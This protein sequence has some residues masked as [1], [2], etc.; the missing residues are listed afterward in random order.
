MTILKLIK[1][2]RKD[3]G[4]LFVGALAVI[5]VIDFWLIDLP[6]IFKGGFKL[7]QIVY[8]L[9]MSYIS[10]FI[11]YFLVVHIK[12]QKDKQNL[13]TYI[14]KKVAVI[15]SDAKSLIDEM[16]KKSGLPFSN[17]YPSSDELQRISNLIDPHSEAPLF[18]GYNTNRYANWIQY[19]ANSSIRSKEAIQKIFQKM[20]FLETELINI[21][22]N[23]EDSTHF[24][25]WE[26]IIPTMNSHN[27]QF[28][29]TGQ[30]IFS[31][32]F[33]LIQQLEV[34]SDIKLSKYK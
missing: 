4:F 32:Y 27:L 18:L 10:A 22:A 21:L 28:A 19:F 6:D 24:W 1:S 11:F 2:I 14:D 3:L 15:L 33:E 5:C 7:G 30:E 34:Y 20:P 13:Y 12:Q 9:C 29:N 26:K 17:R 8:K 23:I 31:K 16:S 25:I